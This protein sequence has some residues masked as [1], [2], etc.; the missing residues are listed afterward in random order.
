MT[1]LKESFM[2]L[3]VIAANNN[4]RLASVDIRAAFLQLKVL[5]RDVYFKPLEY[6]RK[7]GLIWRLKK[8][9][10]ILMMHPPNSG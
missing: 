9:Y 6:V 8:H 7:P 1:P 4:F 5:D 2:L 10:T 3:M